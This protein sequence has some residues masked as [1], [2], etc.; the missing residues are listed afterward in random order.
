MFGRHRGFTREKE[1]A[2]DSIGV[3]RRLLTYFRPFVGSVVIVCLLLLFNA[4]FEVVSPYL[5][6][7]AVDRFI[8]PSGAEGPRWLA[9][10]VP[11]GLAPMG[12]LAR[13]MWILL[14]IYL[15][16]WLSM[17]AQ[18]YL[19]NVMGQKVLFK[20][21]T[22]ILERIHS[23]SLDFFDAHEAGDLMS[24]LVNDTQVINQVFTM[25]IVRLLGVSL[26]LVGI[27]VTM[28]S[29]KWDLALAS[30][31]I[32][33]AMILTTT[34]FA[35]R[36]RNAFRE[37][38]RT[39]GEVSSELEENI[40]GVREVQAFARERQ[41]VAE[42][43][44]INRANRDANVQAQTLTSAFSPALDV[45]SNA[46]L[47]IVLGY[48]GWSVLQGWT[49]VGMVVGYMTYVQRFYR[50]IQMLSNLWAT[51]QS[52]LAGAERIFELLDTTPAVSDAPDSQELPPAQGRI[53]FENVDFYYKPEEPVLCGVN[54]TA[55][56]GQT[57]AL[58]GPTGAGKTSIVSLLMRFYDVVGG[59]I[60]VDGHD[61]RGV[62]QASLREQMGIVLQDTFLFSGTLM[63]NIRYGRL[64][65]T[66]D[67]VIEA[68][69]L[70]N[71]H[72]F[73]T[74]LP[75]GYSTDIGERGHNLSQ[76]QRQLISIAR[77]ILADP[78]ILILDEATSSV[79]TRTELLIQRALDKLLHGRTSF[80]IAHRLSTIRNADQVLFVDEGEIVERGTHE[81]LM[82]Q[83]GKY[84]DL[85]MSQFRREEEPDQSPVA[86]EVSLGGDGSKPSL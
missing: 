14:G 66:D 36:A 68:A 27:V 43:R 39:I 23:L 67:E 50:P 52:A 19:M 40:S 51:L 29:R 6:E 71:A 4:G 73:V 9:L 8:V 77:A 76:G 72:D 13:V 30:F 80:V 33:P 70:A 5:I 63:D 86:A 26:N 20:M 3:L 82:A 12:G 78:R 42:F 61:I 21:R 11:E 74:R 85:Y 58:V 54:L 69:K 57:V 56:P 62:T 1:R 84:Y 17:G 47:A 53:V 46:A 44:Q 55:Q 79:D 37:T 65:A 2:K 83:R 59:S 7:V 22:Q 38:R 28:V 34:V 35:R 16:R 45:L 75:E 18:A 41:N 31:A 48:G 15:L 81:T 24:R 60:S 10:I 25:G 64:D 49:T 32:L